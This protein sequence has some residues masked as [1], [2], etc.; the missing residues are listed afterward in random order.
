MGSNSK[1]ALAVKTIEP[2]KLKQWLDHGNVTLVD[3]RE[4]REYRAGHIADAHQMPL[5]RI[6]ATHLPK[7]GDA[8]VVYCLKGARGLSACEKLLKQN[9]SMKIFNLDGGIDAWSAAGLPTK[10]DGSL[11]LPLD[12]QVQLT[13]GLILLLA[14]FLTAFWNSLSVLAVAVIGAGLTVAGATGFC[15][16]ARIMAYAPWNK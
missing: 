12:R 3:V 5:G 2:A 9:P 10:S 16:L 6:D 1:T 8:I 7:G 15:G 13:I 14:S 4:G 11:T